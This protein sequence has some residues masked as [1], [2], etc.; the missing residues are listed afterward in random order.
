[1]TNAHLDPQDGDDGPEDDAVD[2]QGREVT[3]RST[4]NARRREE[5]TNAHLDPQDGDDGPEDDAVGAVDASEVDPGR[6]SPAELV[7]S[8]R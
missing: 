3:A 2:A 6:S 4:R 8:R 1:V 7:S 5:V